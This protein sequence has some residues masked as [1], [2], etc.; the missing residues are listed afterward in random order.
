MDDI[1]DAAQVMF[2]EDGIGQDTVKEL[3]EVCLLLLLLPL[4]TKCNIFL[5]LRKTSS[6]ISGPSRFFTSLLD[7]RS[8]SLLLICL[9]RCVVALCGA[10]FISGG[11]KRGKGVFLGFLGG[12]SSFDSF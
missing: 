4:A 6:D 9:F 11:T 5:D 1:I 7:L 12:G 10:I 2:E 3:R 8:V